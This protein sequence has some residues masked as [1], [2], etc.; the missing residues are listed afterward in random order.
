MILNPTRQLS[1]GALVRPVR[2]KRL[3]VVNVY[4]CS[5]KLS[6]FGFSKKLVWAEK[7][8]TIKMD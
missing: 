8:L 7:S 6:P 1:A 2:L 5:R 3:E 4:Q